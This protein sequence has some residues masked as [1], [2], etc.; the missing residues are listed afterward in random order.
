MA[1]ILPL[2]PLVACFA[3]LAA[4]SCQKE[5]EPAAA[6]SARSETEKPVLGIGQI[7][8]V[9]PVNEDAA[10]ISAASDE[11]KTAWGA[12][13]DGNKLDVLW[14]DGDAVKLYGAGTPDGAVYTAAL[15][16]SSHT[17]TFT[18]E[19]AIVEDAQ[20]YA[21]YPAEMA[22]AMQGGKIPVDL[23]TFASQDY[24]SSLSM[25]GIKK[26]YDDQGLDFK[27][28]S[29]VPHLP[30]FSSSAGD[31]FQ[32]QNLCGG[33]N[34]RLNDYQGRGIRIASV[35]ITT[36]K[37][38][39]GTMLVNPADGSV[40]LTGSSDDQ[41]SITVVSSA[42]GTAVSGA[43]PGFSTSYSWYFFLPVGTYD[44]MTFT[45]TDTEGNVYVR[46]TGNAITVNPGKVGRFP[47][48]HLTVYYGKANCIIAEPGA[49]VD[50]DI[51]PYYTFDNGF[52]YAS[53]QAVS[54][55]NFPALTAEVIWEQTCKEGDNTNSI[56]GGNTGIVIDGAPEIVGNNILR[57]RTVSSTPSGNALVAIK[58]GGTV[59]W[60]YHVWVINHANM[61]PPAH[62]PVNLG[63]NTYY[64]LD[65]NI[66]AAYGS[67]TNAEKAYMTYG[68]LYQWGRKDPLPISGTSTYSDGA[69]VLF[70]SGERRNACV[71]ELLNN[72]LE[73]ILET[74]SNKS[75]LP[76]NKAN[77]RLWGAPAGYGTTTASVLTSYTE[78]FSKSV[79]D[80]CPEGYMVP[81]AYYYS[82]LGIGISTRYGYG[83]W[84]DYDGQNY[85]YFAL[86]GY[87]GAS[88]ETVTAGATKT[89]TA[90]TTGWLWCSNPYGTGGWAGY[91]YR[92][93]VSGGNIV[94][95]NTYAASGA[96][97]PVR[98]MRDPASGDPDPGTNPGTSSTVRV[99]IM[100]DSISTFQDWIPNNFAAFYPRT[101]SNGKSLT[102]V[103]Q[104]WWYRLIYDLMPDAVLDRNLSYSATLVT[105][106]DSGV[107]TDNWTFP[108]RCSMYE[109]PDIII[110]HGGTNDRGVSRGYMVPLG[111]Y[112]WDT[113][114]NDLDIRSFRPA[115][116][117]TIRQLQANYPGV[118]IVCVINSVL[119][120]ENTEDETKNYKLLADSI[121]EIA[122]HYGLPVVSLQGVDFD[123]LEG[124]HPD[125]NGAA[126]IANAVYNK[127]S[128]EGLLE[129]KR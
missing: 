35:K 79:Y 11:T 53:G 123:T 52:S 118:K 58:K 7:Y 42:A 31:E 28:K 78:G 41:K 83:A 75:A 107:Q 23:S 125:S 109:N 71:Q 116:I 126:V 22:G 17:A 50:I 127:L 70:H 69:T 102:D 87:V 13:Y 82:G 90:G 94:I 124:L 54:N 129:Y 38:I 72:P 100:G 47:V 46:S 104:T 68:L 95:G 2:K 115:Y 81:Q 117:K 111:D 59:V 21:V 92:V 25:Y 14:L 27:E 18:A 48:S 39:S 120:V 9:T 3:L 97:L 121:Q 26:N 12:V 40:T 19:N 34:V 64:L 10:E 6:P 37:Y 36:N 99:G 32:F 43:S 1:K 89:T 65:R 101:A 105:K 29:I 44:G 55:E 113:P 106:I 15:D 91:S 88:A 114:V 63:G 66:G 20:R 80:P 122:D 4:F 56:T 110:I 86:P 93:Y 33:V 108:T 77:L 49:T 24:H 30:L 74:G 8:C 84:L 85:A 60:S 112:D 98:C 73:R 128:Q 96:S 103:G 76:Q 45:I 61:N 5:E 62:V 67:T 119:Y 16:A 57:I 51:T